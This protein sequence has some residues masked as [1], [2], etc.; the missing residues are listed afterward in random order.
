[1]RRGVKLPQ[2]SGP[3]CVNLPQRSAREVRITVTPPPPPARQ[4]VEPALT[5]G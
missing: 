5:C 1:V 2:R 4:M 3:R